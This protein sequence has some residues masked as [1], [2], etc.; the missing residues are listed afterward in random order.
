MNAETRQNQAPCRSEDM[1]PLPADRCLLQCR[2]VLLLQG[3]M[4]NFFNRVAAW[5]EKNGVS[6]RKI[7]FNGGDWLFHRHL[8]A[9]DYWGTLGAFPAFLRRYIDSHDIDGIVCFG[10][11]RPYHQAAAVVA[12]SKDIPFFVFEEGYV[13][14]HYIT[15]ELGGVNMFSMLPRS[16]DFYQALPDLDVPEPRSTHASFARAALSATMYY[17]AG[18]VLRRRYPSYQHHRIFSVT[19]E[20]AVW[21]RSWF[22][23]KLNKWRDRPVFERLLDQHDD[24]YFAAILQ[25]H[26][27]SQVL[28][29]SEYKDVREF[30]E[31]VMLSF[32]AHADKRRHLV[33]KHHPMDRGSRDYRQLINSL[34]ARLDV[35]GRVHYVHDV[36]LPTL[37]RHS[38]GVITINSTVGM[39]ALYHGKPVKA[40][41]NALYDFPGLTFQGELNQFWLFQNQIDMVLWRRFRSF[42]ITQTQLNASFYGR[43]FVSIME[44]REAE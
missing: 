38:R 41:G 24:N 34:A 12:V 18:W 2:R 31:E 13:R 17:V 29:H 43:D 25:V 5:L 27:D 40:M 32:S 3:P 1:L 44:E 11:C 28:Q 42:L 9:T 37:L 39:S 7:N 36:H 14:P 8:N 33:F 26:N 10:D 16:T 23:K 15:L 6:V 30:I 20:A 19:Y 35:A 21:I 4:G 22:R